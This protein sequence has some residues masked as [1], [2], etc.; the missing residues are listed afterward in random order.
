MKKIWKAVIDSKGYI[1]LNDLENEGLGFG[2]NGRVIF[3]KRQLQRYC[4]DEK[5]DIN[6]IDISSIPDMDEKEFYSLTGYEPLQDDLI[7]VNCVNAGEIGHKNCGWC[8]KC[9]LPKYSCSCI[10]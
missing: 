10:F 9:N 4:I 6:S 8:H 2:F 5:M 3:T 7:R 1:F